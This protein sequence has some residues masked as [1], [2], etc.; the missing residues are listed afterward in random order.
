M[1]VDV[2]VCM[3][4]RARI[5]GHKKIFVDDFLQMVFDAHLRNIDLFLGTIIPVFS[6]EFTEK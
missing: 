5:S 4:M 3:Y 6:H 1:C 2:C